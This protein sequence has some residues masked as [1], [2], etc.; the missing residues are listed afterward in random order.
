MEQRATSTNLKSSAILRASSTMEYNSIGAEKIGVTASLCEPLATYS[1]A[2]QS[3][4]HG[5]HFSHGQTQ[6]A[7]SDIRVVE[8]FAG[9]GGFRVGFERASWRFKTVW[10][11][12]WEPSTKRQDTG[13]I[14]RR[15]FGEMGFCGKDICAVP[16]SEI[17]DCDLLCAGF[18]CQDYSVATTLSR[19][20][21]IEGKKGV[22]WWQIYR[23]LQ[24]KGDSRPRL[25]VLENVDRLLSSPASQRGRDFAI[26]LATLSDLGYVVEWSGESSTPPNT[27]CRNGASGL[28]WWHI[29]PPLPSARSICGRRMPR[30]GSW[31][32]AY[33]PKPS[34]AGSAQNHQRTYVSR[35]T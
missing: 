19:S 6:V 2:V 28:T 11:N 25:V 26:I 22:L 27:G 10:S 15:Q 8:L 21:G 34:P 33:C 29:W 4:R 35:E 9:V 23:I 16:T 7:K 17:P 12:Q 1:R 30:S 13:D 32:M 31:R 18:P 24:E 3:E 5:R 20:G 14:Y